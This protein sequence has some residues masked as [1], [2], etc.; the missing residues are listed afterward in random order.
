MALFQKNLIL[1]FKA[2][3]IRESH[4]RPESMEKTTSILSGLSFDKFFVLNQFMTKKQ[5]MIEIF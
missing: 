4:E 2:H 1:N 3:N 5:V